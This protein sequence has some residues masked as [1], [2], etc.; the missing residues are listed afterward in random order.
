[1]IDFVKKIINK[2]IGDSAYKKNIL[3]M[4]GGR[5]VAQLIPILITPIITR[6]YSPEEFGLFAVFLTIASF[7]AMISNGRYCLAILLPKKKINAQRLVLISIIFTSIVSLLFVVLVWI[8]KNQFLSLFNI[9]KL[10]GHL[11]LFFLTILFIGFHEALY[12]YFLREKRYKK[13]AIFAIIQAIT[14]ISVRL[15]LGLMGNTNTGLIVSY[16]SGYSISTVLLLSNLDFKFNIKFTRGNFKKL[17]IRYISFLKYSLFSDSLSVLA[18][19]SPNVLINKVFGSTSAGYFSLSEKVLGSP[20]WFVTS[21][22]SDVFKQ[23]F[24]EQNRRGK[25]CKILFLKTFKTLL[26]VGLIPFTFIFILSPY[27]I[28]PLLGEVWSP[29]GEYIRIFSIMYYSSFVVNPLKSVAYLIKKQQ[30]MIVFELLKLIS[31]ISAFSMGFYLKDIKIVL[32]LWSL[33]VTFVNIIIFLI[34]YRLVKEMSNERK[35]QKNTTIN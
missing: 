33:L 19:T 13:I 18:S 4:S 27:V 12:Y 1:M 15:I 20:I 10:D 23:E 3:L 8:F 2:Y 25:D 17:I 29:V 26:F 5:V 9:Q 35:N 21:S 16:L 28:P 32:I 11:S 7:I 31:I 22:V 6:I 30:Y 24:S 34:I 14:M